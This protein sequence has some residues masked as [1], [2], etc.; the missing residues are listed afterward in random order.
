MKAPSS[1]SVGCGG[2][3]KIFSQRMTESLN[4]LVTEVF[5]E[6]PLA[7]PGCAKNKYIYLLF[8]YITYSIIYTFNLLNVHIINDADKSESLTLAQKPHVLFNA[9]IYIFVAIN[10]FF[11]VFP[12]GNVHRVSIFRWILKI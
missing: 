9:Y 5:V 3:V 2:A 12:P 6:Q 1:T 11:N 8:T 10:T 4:E 7:L